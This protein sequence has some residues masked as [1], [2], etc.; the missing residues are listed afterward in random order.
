MNTFH[1]TR[2]LDIPL[3]GAPEQSIRPGPEIS[4]V[5]LL[6][7]DYIGLKP[8]LLV[9]EGDRVK[10]GQPLFTDKKN[11]DLQFT[12]PGCGTVKEINRGAKRKFESLVISLDGNEQTTFPG[13]EGRAV[14]KLSAEEIRSTLQQSGLWCGFRTRPYGKIPGVEARPASLFVTA[15]D[16]A[17]LAPD[18]QV[19]LAEQREDFLLG[20]DILRRF[21]PVP[22]NLCVAEGFD[23]SAVDQDQIHFHC[24]KGPHP[25]GLPSTHIHFIDPVHTG[26]EVWHICYQDVVGI[27]HLFRTGTIATERVISLAGPEIS[28][29]CL[30]RTRIGASITELCAGKLSEKAGNRI[31]SGSVLDGRKAAGIHDYLGR[32]HRQVSVIREGSGRGFLNWYMPGRDRFSVT[33]LFLSSFL[34]ERKFAMNCALWGGK[35]AIFP[36]GTYEK[37]MPLD[38][39][40]IS[41]LKSLASRDVEKSEALGCLELIEEDLALCTFVCPGKNNYGPMLRDMLTIMEKES[42]TDGAP[43]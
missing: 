30:V 36:L 5:A 2:G 11:Q 34:G 3:A 22:L 20:L 6:G 10:L 31:L 42:G 33:R 32:Y 14:D 37:V 19:V 40:A 15:I 24:F 28:A 43:S 27:G 1:L 13:L 38:I 7:D 8:T 12:S 9:Q 18:P 23:P 39:V 4:H 25:A 17:P 16:T 26:K 21:L 41:L 29:P 35:R